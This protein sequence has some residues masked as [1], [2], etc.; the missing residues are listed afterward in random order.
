MTRGLEKMGGE[1]ILRCFLGFLSIYVSKH[2]F[3]S[4][5]STLR[6]L[7]VVECSEDVAGEQVE[8]S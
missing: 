3:L 8:E 4:H 2:R 5:S 7:M 6:G 1:L